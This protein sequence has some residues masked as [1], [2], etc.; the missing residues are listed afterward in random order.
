[1]EG[2]AEGDGKERLKML[3]EARRLHVERRSVFLRY[4]IAKK[5]K[6]AN[7]RVLV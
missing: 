4:T 3:V 7:R 2:E 1:M 5:K 6:N